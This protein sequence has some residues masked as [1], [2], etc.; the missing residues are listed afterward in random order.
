MGSSKGSISTYLEIAIT[1][2]TALLNLRK[3]GA[4]LWETLGDCPSGKAPI[5]AKRL[6]SILF[7]VLETIE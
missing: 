3:G 7:S 6:E 4:C 2:L 1:V 5:L